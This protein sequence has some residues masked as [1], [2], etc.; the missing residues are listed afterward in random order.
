MS[1]G[2]PS[3]DRRRSHG[4]DAELSRRRFASLFGVGALAVGGLLSACGS[5]DD[6][7]GAGSDASSGA[8]AAS[9]F[10]VTVTHKF[11]T[12]T[13]PSAPKRVVSVGVTE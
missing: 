11:G 3:G 10:P 5:D 7:T 2:T 12:T 13:V 8:T 4:L 9:V 6:T 1:T